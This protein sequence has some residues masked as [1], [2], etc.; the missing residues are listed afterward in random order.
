MLASGG[1]KNKKQVAL[2]TS[3]GGRAHSLHGM[4]G[5]VC[6]GVLLEGWLRW[7]A[8]PF[9]VFST[10]GLLLPDT[11][12]FAP[13]SSEMAVYVFLVFVSFGPEFAPTAHAR[14]YFQS[15]VVSL[16]FVAGGEGVRCKPRNPAAEGPRSHLSPGGW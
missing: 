16:H 12:V 3:Q 13:R 11:Q 15:H 1:S 6:P 7:F 4:R 5:R 2:L 10:G 9:V 14:G 8:H